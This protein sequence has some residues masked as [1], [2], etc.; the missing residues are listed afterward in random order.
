MDR[1]KEKAVTRSEEPRHPPLEGDPGSRKNAQLLCQSWGL[2]SPAPLVGRVG[3][4]MTNAWP[5]RPDG[6]NHRPPAAL[7]LPDSSGSESEF[8]PGGLGTGVAHGRRKRGRRSTS[9]QGRVVATPTPI[10]L[11]L[12]AR[13]GAR[14]LGRPPAAGESIAGPARRRRAAPGSGGRTVGT[15]GWVGR[16][17][18][19]GTAAAASF[20]KLVA[21][22]GRHRGWRD[23]YDCSRRK[24]LNP[25]DR[26]TPWRRA[27]YQKPRSGFWSPLACGSTQQRSASETDGQGNAAPQ[28]R[29]PRGLPKPRGSR[30]W[31]WWGWGRRAGS[32]YG[33][34]VG[35]RRRTAR[36]AGWAQR[37]IRSRSPDCRRGCGA[38][39][40]WMDGGGGERRGVV[41]RSRAQ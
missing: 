29:G 35:H 7:S 27:V 33:E 22:G 14:L 18:A 1:R 13:R 5:P 23:A 26:K 24:S 37:S 39:K 17:G 9:P 8:V 36:A 19:V 2:E 40:G 41:R 32:G 11:G 34:P 15:A 3:R 28:A 21:S 31:R 38:T 12:P 6:S 25:G 30:W 20:C 4:S 16:A 10:N